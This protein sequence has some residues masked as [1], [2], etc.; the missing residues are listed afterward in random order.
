M[1][2]YQKLKG[3]T[4]HCDILYMSEINTLIH[5]IRKAQASLITLTVAP[6]YSS[7]SVAV[8]RRAQDPETEAAK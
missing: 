1:D 6:L 4:V 5:H 7:V 2:H 3:G 8:S